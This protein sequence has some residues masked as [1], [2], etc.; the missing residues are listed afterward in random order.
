[1]DKIDLSQIEGNRNRPVKK[2]KPKVEEAKAVDKPAVPA[3]ETPKPAEKVIEKPV[4][5]VEAPKSEPVAEV[6]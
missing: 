1:M 4:E 5:K 6:P 2:D 3:K